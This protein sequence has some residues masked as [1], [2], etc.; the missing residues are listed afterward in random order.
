LPVFDSFSFLLIFCKNSSFQ[1]F[2]ELLAIIGIRKFEL[3]AAGSF[4]EFGELLSQVRAIKFADRHVE[5]AI[6]RLDVNSYP[7]AAA[8]G[9]S[10]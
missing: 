6:L 7:L 5:E 9:Q 2:F 4:L 10:R 1:I 3:Q 8:L